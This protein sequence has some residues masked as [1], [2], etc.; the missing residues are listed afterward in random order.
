MESY[1]KMMEDKIF[2]LGYDDKFTVKKVLDFL[3]KPESFRSFG[4]GLKYI[5]SKKY[6]QFEE[7][8][9][10]NPK[11]FI[12]ECCHKNDVYERD[13]CDSDN[14][15]VNW[16]KI[17]TEKSG[18]K[19]GGPKGGETNRKKLFA[20][21]FA[22]DLNVEET[23]YLFHNVYFDRAFNLKNTDEM[24]YYYCKN[25]GKSW[26]D[27]K[28]LIEKAN[29]IILEQTNQNSHTIFT[30]YIKEELNRTK[31]EEQLLE[32]ISE[33]VR[34]LCKKNSAAKRALQIQK[35]SA[36]ET[37]RKEAE[38]YK[39]KGEKKQKNSMAFLYSMILDQLDNTKLYKS[40][41]NKDPQK[42]VFV[43]GSKTV[44]GK[45]AR[46]RDSIKSNFP[47]AS[48][49]SKEDLNYEEIRKLIILLYSY[50]T[51]YNNKDID[52][53]EYVEELDDILYDSGLPP[54]Y[55]GNPYDWLFLYCIL[56]N[57]T[58]EECGS[59]SIMDSDAQHDPLNNFRVIINEALDE[60]DI[61]EFSKQ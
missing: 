43:R 8:I 41:K 9:K 46:I 15:L 52:I 38:L 3:N 60:D 22:L 26:N 27:A 6:P 39:Y 59:L 5:M 7:K 28:R 56:A 53:E 36:L 30:K 55:Y 25:N 32:Y 35:E 58:E 18:V 49:L 54:L 34:D 1:T 42:D 48:K 61:N 16:F 4:D 29:K 14:T 17:R 2:E 31:S 21:S 40:K 57:F 13:I 44:F 19:E 10:Q 20:L 45:N 37:A 47:E 51:W 23:I 24:I 11:A 12:K 33:H 50:H